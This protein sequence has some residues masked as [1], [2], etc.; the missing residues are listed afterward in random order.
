VR[1]YVSGRDLHLGLIILAYVFGP[2]VW[3]WYGLFLG[4]MV[5]VLGVHF[6]RLVLPELVAGVEIEPE[7]SGTADGSIV[8]GDLPGQSPGDDTDY[9]PGTSDEAATPGGTEEPAGGSR[10]A[11]DPED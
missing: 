2:L 11:T 7:P 3:G 1:P 10:D 4:P 9:L 5:L 8:H 6:G